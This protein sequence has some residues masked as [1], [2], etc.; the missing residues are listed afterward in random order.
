M[1]VLQPRARHTFVR[2]PVIANPVDAADLRGAPSIIRSFDLYTLT[3][4]DLD[5]FGGDFSFKVEGTKNARAAAANAAATTTTA[6][7]TAGVTAGATAGAT[8]AA[9]AIETEMGA[10]MKNGGGKGE[11]RRGGE[12]GKVC[13]AIGEGGKSD[14]H[15]G[16][17]GGKGEG[18]DGGARGEGGRKTKGGGAVRARLSVGG[19]TA[20]NHITVHGLCVWFDCTLLAPPT[21]KGVGGRVGGARG[22]D[23]E[24][25]GGDAGGSTSIYTSSEEQLNTEHPPPHPPVNTQPRPDN[26]DRIG[27][28]GDG[29]V[30]FST[31]PFES[32]THWKQANLL[33]DAPLPP[34]PDVRGVSVCMDGNVRFR[35][36]MKFPRH[37]HITVRASTAAAPVVKKMFA[38]WR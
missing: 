11:Q 6:K 30:E 5:A 37:Y 19:G 4:E 33:F 29:G 23:G 38:L 7:A 16:A 15:G 31:S 2:R 21:K 14:E 26:A 34:M 18:C 1:S 24:C 36:N 28:T 35:R 17:C 13:G 10:T 27:D 32:P 9:T 8:A 3:T 12:A 20:H 25:I 22:E